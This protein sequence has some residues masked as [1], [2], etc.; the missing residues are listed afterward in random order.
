MQYSFPALCC[1]CMIFTLGLY[2]QK[3]PPIQT[4]RPDQTECPFLVPAHHFQ[5]E[6]GIN[7]EKN[8]A[9]NENYLLPTILTKY[10]VNDRFELRL[11]SEIAKEKGQPG[12]L[13]PIAL[14]FKT[15]LCQ[16]KGIIP[17]T[18]FIAHLTLPGAASASL[19]NT[20]YAP[21]FRFTMQHSLPH[22]MSLSYN[23][24]AEWD[25]ENPEPVFL[26]TLSFGFSLSEKTGGYSE[27][28]GFAPQHNNPD[29]RCG[30]GL[31]YL[32]ANNILLDISGGV[33]ITGN[34]PHWYSALGASV[35]L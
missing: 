3:L 33:G 29:H 13:S 7:Y 4:D 20:W 31:Y 21:S 22:Q 25:G 24:G 30:A 27:L 9:Q 35:R 26:Y 12:G 5:I 15:S 32:P 14:G 16:E 1:C 2:A 11:I 8:D 17:T 28:Y 23:L 6:T 19:Q 18:S 10:G 34:A